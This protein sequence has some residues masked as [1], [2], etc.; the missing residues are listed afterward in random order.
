[1]ELHVCPMSRGAFRGRAGSRVRGG[2]GS[3]MIDSKNP[4]IRRFV[5]RGFKFSVHEYL[6]GDETSVVCTASRPD[7]K[8]ALHGRSRTGDIAQAL[9]DLEYQLSRIDQMTRR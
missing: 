4:T 5:Q 9:D 8:L 6:R 1:M 3:R 7:T 2:R